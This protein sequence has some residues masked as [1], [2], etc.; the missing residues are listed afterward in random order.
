MHTPFIGSVY[1]YILPINGV[2]IYIYD[3]EN[4]E[5]ITGEGNVLT[6]GC[7]NFTKEV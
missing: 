3:V 7:P 1:I 2:Y 5:A 4:M 6:L